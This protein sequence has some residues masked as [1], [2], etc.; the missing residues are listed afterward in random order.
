MKTIENDCIGC[1]CDAYPC[2]GNICPRRNA[3]HYYCDECG[4]EETL[5]YYEGQELC[6][7]CIENRLEKVGGREE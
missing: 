4:S 2:L 1:A 6:I 5:Y 7:N 3:V